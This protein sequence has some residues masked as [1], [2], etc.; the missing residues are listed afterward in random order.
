MSGNETLLNTL[1]A[2]FRANADSNKL[3]SNIV[4]DAKTLTKAMKDASN[5]DP[6]LEETIK[7]DR[8]AIRT[9]IKNLAEYV[10]TKYGERTLDYVSL[11]DMAKRHKDTFNVKD[12]QLQYFRI[13][14]NEW[15]NGKSVALDD[16]NDNVVANTIGH[17]EPGFVSKGKV[18]IASDDDKKAVQLIDVLHET[19]KVDHITALQYF[20]MYEDI[21]PMMTNAIFNP[22]SGHFQ[23]NINNYTDP[24]LVA[25]F[26]PKIQDIEKRFLISN[27]ATILHDKVHKPSQIFRSLADM[28]LFYNMTSTNNT[29]LI[30][31]NASV[32]RDL[33]KRCVIQQ[34][35]RQLVNMMRQGQ[36]YDPRNP[37]FLDSLNSCRMSREEI[38]FLLNRDPSAIMRRI[39]SALSY[40]PNYLTTI[41]PL[42]QVGVVP[43]MVA[44]QDV[45]QV[46]MINVFLPQ[47]FLQNQNGAGIN[48]LDGVTNGTRQLLFQ[49]GMMIQKDVK[50][51]H[52]EQVLVFD[53][54]RRENYT[55]SGINGRLNMSP[56]SITGIVQPTLNETHVS[57]PYRF[58]YDNVISSRLVRNEELKS[59]FYLRSAIVEQ[60]NASKNFTQTKTVLFKW[61][62]DKDAL[63]PKEC[64]IYDPINS[65]MKNYVQKTT[66]VGSVSTEG[67]FV[68]VTARPDGTFSNDLDNINVNDLLSKNGTIF[69]Y[70][71][72]VKN[73]VTG[74]MEF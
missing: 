62:D 21:S 37:L 39:F 18:E 17:I 56:L 33:H 47:S 63:T 31:D 35:I 34:Q 20:N 71:K 28:E 42:P 27:M 67:P 69:V 8:E 53:V 58:S 66:N 32:W 38:P 64:Y 44:Q 9:N 49:N 2:Q 50:I 65:I 14:Y 1:E 52:T 46:P 7:R 16:P 12:E 68:Q 41:T 3:F 60:Y 10:F 23:M 22:A 72:R 36:I 59:H 74:R 19:S 29:H 61:S 57:V 45:Y 48:L 13:F 30:C 73:P 51:A 43:P 5:K 6:K 11:F 55:I 24:V 70:A 26:G 40:A 54:R 4:N 15:T 25:L